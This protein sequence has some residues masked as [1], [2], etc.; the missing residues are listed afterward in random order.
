MAGFRRAGHILLLSLYFTYVPYGGKF[1]EGLIFGYYRYFWKYK[2]E[3]HSIGAH[4]C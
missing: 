1:S 4:I 2:S 3:D